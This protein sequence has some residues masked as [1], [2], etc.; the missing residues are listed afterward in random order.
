MFARHV[1]WL[2][3]GRVRVVSIPELLALPP[4]SDAVALT[5]DDGFG[6]F[7]TEAAPLLRGLPVTVFVVTDHVGRTNAWRGQRSAEIPT[8]PL[9]DWPALGALIE[10]GVTIGVHTRTHPDLTQITLHDLAQ[11]VAGA[12]DRVRAEL[13]VVPESFAY[14]YGAVNDATAVVVRET[15][16]YACTTEFRTLN[17]SID[18]ARLPR[19]D[20][21]YFQQPEQLESWGRRSFQAYLVCRRML[22]RG[23]RLVTAIA[24][25]EART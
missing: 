5:F 2:R 3:S 23:R 12:V 21:Y 17:Q 13:G 24:P 8:L 14:P 9:L 1:A 20:T 4:V 6:N 22:Q 15:F 25:A 18:A 11:E 16:R 19:L 10:Q 7:A